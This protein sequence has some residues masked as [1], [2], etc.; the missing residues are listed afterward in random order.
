MPARR[1]TC[2]AP[3]LL[4]LVLAGGAVASV[5]PAVAGLQVALRERG[6]YAGPVDGIAGPRTAG[7]LTAFQ[8]RAGLAVDGIAGPRTRAALGRLGRPGYGSRTIVAGKVGWDVSVLQFLL[9]RR[10][11]SPGPVDGAFGPLTE[12]SLRRFQGSAGLVVD[13]VAGRQTFAALR[14]STGDVRSTIDFWSAR[15]GVDPRLARALA[16][17]ES[18]FQNDIVSPAGAWGV[19]QVLPATWSFVEEVL[20]GRR[21][22]RTA[23]GN[24]RVGVAH[25]S[26]LLRAFGG[27]ER[28]ALAAYYQGARA[29]RTLGV[30]PETRTYV[31]NVL[32][33]KGRV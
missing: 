2:L 12:R 10:G 17:Q 31:A 14:A 24:V 25:L 13:G 7:G 22:P 30:L 27:D 11:F 18:G 26:H 6:L 8:R 16:W 3:L 15:Y 21:V 23:A 33:L 9:A 4:A 5:D 20:L 19:M 29:V 1:L 28:L 32:A